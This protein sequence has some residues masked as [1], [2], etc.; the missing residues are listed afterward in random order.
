MSAWKPIVFGR[1]TASKSLTISFQLCMPPQQISPS[2]ASRSPKSSATVQASRNV[3][4]IF[5]VLPAGSL[6]HS[7]GVVVRGID[8]DVR[9]E[10]E[11]IDA[12]ELDAI[13]FRRRRQVEHRI[14]LDRRF[15]I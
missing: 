2:A 15:R 6:A 7:L 4:A 12:V 8:I 14:Q 3:S 9:R 11:Q 5:L 1:S 13:H 10:Q